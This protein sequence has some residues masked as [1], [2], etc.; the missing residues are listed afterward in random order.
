MDAMTNRSLCVGLLLIVAGGYT[1]GCASQQ[2]GK[3]Q[4]IAAAKAR[5]ARAATQ[6]TDASETKFAA[7]STPAELLARQTE[8][9]AK[10][11]S[12]EGDKN[13]VPDIHDYQPDVAPKRPIETIHHPD[14]VHLD[15]VDRA[16][17]VEGSAIG[18]P[19]SALINPAPQLKAT[20]STDDP[21][22]VPESADFGTTSAGAKDA[23][24]VRLRKRMRDNPHDIVAQLD[25][26]LY[27]MLNDDPAPELASVTE[28]P[29]DDQELVSALIDGLS[30]FRSTV[31]EDSNM[32]TEKKIQPLLEMA[33]R[34]RSQ[35]DLTVSTVALCK[36]VEAYGKYDPI[37]PSRFGAG[38][39]NA[40]IVYCEVENFMPKQ[41]G[42]IWK[43]RLTEQVTL[44]TDTGMLAWS[45]DRRD[46]TDE[47]R[48]RR[49]DFFAY[50]IVH[51]PASL[52][53]GRYM[54]KVSIE[55]KNSDRV[56]ESTVPLEIVGK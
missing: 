1:G 13:A 34:L 10:P 26:Q 18:Q 20:V 15:H 31:R 39:E 50:N 24:G 55:D 16:S 14:H 11:F 25:L 38:K 2:T 32:L 7:S 44:Y 5:A 8:A 47:C 51:L 41:E 36:K 23:L 46:V 29:S 40:A 9:Y 53:V 54:L 4:A 52:T 45:D 27:G 37:T 30:N 49:H 56:A 12:P 48:N 17:D 22:I 28:L 33:E 43:T 3:Q 19:A 21:K 35:A 6:P 42:M